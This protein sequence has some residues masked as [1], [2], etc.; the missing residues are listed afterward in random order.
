[1][2]ENLGFD[3]QAERAGTL[4]RR[5]S[6]PQGERIARVILVRQSLKRARHQAGFLLADQD[7][8]LTG[9][10]KSSGAMLNSG[11]TRRSP[12]G[13]PPFRCLTC[14]ALLS[15]LFRNDE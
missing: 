11:T 15:G 4:E 1:L 12:G 5:D 13:G 9:L 8:N 7:E 2:D 10:T 3:Q 14:Y 6:G